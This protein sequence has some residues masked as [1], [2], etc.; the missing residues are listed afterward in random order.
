MSENNKPM[1][2]STEDLDIVAGG[3]FSDVIAEA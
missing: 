2:L 1:E 3:A